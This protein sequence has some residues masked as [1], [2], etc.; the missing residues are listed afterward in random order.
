MIIAIDGPAGSGKSS[1]AREVATRLG[2]LFVDTGAMYRA[3]ALRAIQVGVPPEDEAFGDVLSQTII[4][5]GPKD[6]QT[7]VF[8]DGEDVSDLIRTEEVSGMSSRVSKRSDVRLRMVELQRA[9][10]SQH[11]AGGGVVVIEGRDIGTVVFPEADYKFFVT[12][13]P[14]IRAQRRARQLADKGEPVSV[15]ELL[16]QILERDQRDETRPD[17]PLRIADD[18]VVVDTSDVQFEEQ[19]DMI[20]DLISGNAAGLEQ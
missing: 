8:L 4:G 10:T 9:A 5:L 18:A 6:D 2:A 15:E 13:A 14:V 3:L 1:T 16:E 20:L 7:V 19:V 11:I 17:S 12:A